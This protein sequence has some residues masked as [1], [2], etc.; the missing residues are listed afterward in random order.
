M[1]G[2]NYLGTLKI[3]LKKYKNKLVIFE[4]LL[5]LDNKSF[6]LRKSNQEITKNKT[7]LDLNLFALSK[8]FYKKKNAGVMNAHARG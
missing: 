7:D 1:I 3:N 6:V 2:Q 8:P 4:I 5:S